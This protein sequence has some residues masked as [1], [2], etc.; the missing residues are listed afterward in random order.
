MTGFRVLRKEAPGG[1]WVGFKGQSHLHL[2]THQQSEADIR[3]NGKLGPT[4][5][6]CGILLI[7]EKER[8][9][10]RENHRDRK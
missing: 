8:T 3:I 4:Q 5:A 2:I 10:H 6:H 1:G 9:L 7:Q